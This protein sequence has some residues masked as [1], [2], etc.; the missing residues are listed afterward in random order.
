MS[1]VIGNALLYLIALLVYWRKQRRID[2]GF[3]TTF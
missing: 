3:V 1:L 2:Y